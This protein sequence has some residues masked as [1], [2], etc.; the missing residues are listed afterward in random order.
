VRH[1]VLAV[2][3]GVSAASRDRRSGSEAARFPRAA[4]ASRVIGHVGSCYVTI[5]TRVSI[6]WTEP[7]Q[8]CG[9]FRSTTRKSDCEEGSDAWVSRLPRRVAGRAFFVC[10]ACC[11]VFG[12]FWVAWRRKAQVLG[13]GHRAP[14]P[15]AG[16]QPRRG[17]H[18]VGRAQDRGILRSKHHRSRC[19]RRFRA[20]EGCV[21][22]QRDTNPGAHA[23]RLRSVAPSGLK[24]A[25]PPIIRNEIGT[26]PRPCPSRLFI[27]PSQQCHVH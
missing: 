5:K 3:C 11:V 14:A 15:L 1:V 27:I 13:R 16:F 2:S 10:F 20:G 24:T 6:A 8:I 19:C 25:R 22:H 4:Q 23:A 21:R 7:D 18:G 9:K 26:S 17:R 12:S